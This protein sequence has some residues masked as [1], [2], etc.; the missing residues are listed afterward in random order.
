MKEDVGSF[1]GEVGGAG[2]EDF[3]VWSREDLL[4]VLKQVVDPDLHMNIVDLGLVYDVRQK[5]DM[6]EVDMTLTS[7]GCPYGPYLIHGVKQSLLPLRD[8]ND[9]EI[10]IVWDPP[11]GPD[12]M[13]EEGK[14][15]LGFDL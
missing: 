9:V 7:P 14:L 15:E 11:W 4:E 13:T 5:R 3:T 2:R 10:D 8:V 1:E 6:V 12:R